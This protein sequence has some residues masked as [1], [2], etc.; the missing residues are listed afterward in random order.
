MKY[1][2]CCHRA[3]IIL[4]L[5]ITLLFLFPP[6]TLAAMLFDSEVSPYLACK[7]CQRAVYAAVAADTP[8][9]SSE[10]IKKTETQGSFFDPCKNDENGPFKMCLLNMALRA[11]FSS[12]DVLGGVAPEEFREYDVAATFRLPWA[13]YSR[14][15][16]GGGLRLM[17]GAGILNGAGENALVVSFIPLLTFG[18]KDGRFTL[19]M[20]AGGAFLSRRHFGEQD[21]GGYFQFALTAGLSIPL[22]WKLGAGYRFLH[23]SDAAIYGPHNTGVDFHMLEIIYRF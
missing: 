14:S 19:D 22:F 23:Y 21:F 10:M 1:Y 12:F 2:P 8:S 4:S 17:S 18:S 20:G 13:W 6:G 16:W 9:E 3:C 11:R 5:F 7:D 15:G